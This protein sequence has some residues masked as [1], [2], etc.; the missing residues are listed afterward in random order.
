MLIYSN[1]NTILT[2][3]RYCEDKTC[4]FDIYKMPKLAALHNQPH[5]ILDKAALQ[6]TLWRRREKK[7]NGNKTNQLLVAD[8]QPKLQKHQ[9][10]ALERCR[11]GSHKA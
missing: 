7:K 4:C 1:R 11:Q 5:T 6:K 9:I 2:L 10:I 8:F 3:A